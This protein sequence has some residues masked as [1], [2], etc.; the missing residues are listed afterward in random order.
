[1]TDKIT[2]TD[3]GKQIAK[4]AEGN[5]FVAFVSVLE[6]AKCGYPGKS[7]VDEQLAELS[8]NPAAFRATE[9]ENF[10]RVFKEHHDAERPNCR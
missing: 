1:M 10:M 9:D 5:E 3:M 8:G 6:C 2:L 4:D 7:V